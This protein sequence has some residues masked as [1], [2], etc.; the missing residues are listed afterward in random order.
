MAEE[1]WNEI[2]GEEKGRKSL[3]IAV[4]I[5]SIV[6]LLVVIVGVLYKTRH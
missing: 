5:F 6:E 4:I 3:K 2:Y 1:K